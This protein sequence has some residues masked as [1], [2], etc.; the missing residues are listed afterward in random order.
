MCG[1][2]NETMQVR[3]END[4]EFEKTVKEDPFATMKAIKLK[5]HDP[6]KVKCP[7]VTIF[8][9]LDGSFNAEQE[10]EESSMDCTKRFEQVQDNVKSIVGK[11]W[12]HNF[13]ENTKEHINA[14]D[15]NEQTALKE[16]SNERFV[17]H[18]F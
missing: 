12:S 7:F 5:M 14:S 8:E 18:A 10:D 1:H 2:C 15:T 17:A 4:G 3:L 13:V 16:E 11:D 6:S 9:Q